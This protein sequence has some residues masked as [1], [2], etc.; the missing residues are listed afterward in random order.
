M[1]L[2]R[3]DVLKQLAALG[4]VVAV[5]PLVYEPRRSY[6]FGAWAPVDDSARLQALLDQRIRITPGT[7]RIGEGLPVPA[8]RVHDTLHLNNGGAVLEGC[9][10]QYSELPP[11]VIRFAGA[12]VT[13]SA[14]LSCATTSSR[15]DARP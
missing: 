14:R 11:Y 12:K 7:Y 6:F 5:P 1:P 15:G 2:G 8:G 13:V 4:L 10:F 9:A 3:R